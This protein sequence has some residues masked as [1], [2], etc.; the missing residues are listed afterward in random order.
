LKKT[1]RRP[2]L[3]A[4]NTTQKIGICPKQ[5]LKK[6]RKFGVLSTNMNNREDRGWSAWS[7][8]NKQN[9]RG[10]NGAG[11]YRETIRKGELK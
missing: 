11:G 9:K 1:S 3:L 4:K 6:E 2:E 10:K 8:Q 5:A 7:W